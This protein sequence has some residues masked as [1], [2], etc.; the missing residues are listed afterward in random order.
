VPCAVGGTS[1]RLW[2]PGAYDTKT[3]TRPYDDMLYRVTQAMLHG[4]L[5][6][7]LWHQGESDSVMGTDGTDHGCLTQCDWR[8]S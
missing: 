8:R 1:I 5:K 4:T 3:D 7:I 2:Q 6:G